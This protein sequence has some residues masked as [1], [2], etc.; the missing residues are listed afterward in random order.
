MFLSGHDP[1]AKAMDC[2]I[3]R[4]RFWIVSTIIAMGLRWVVVKFHA[5]FTLPSQGNASIQTG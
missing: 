4:F 5:F 2:F 1:E 3:R